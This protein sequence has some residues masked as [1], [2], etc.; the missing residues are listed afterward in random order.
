MYAGTRAPGTR[1]PATEQVPPG[2]RAY[3]WPGLTKRQIILRGTSM[4]ILSDGTAPD[5]TKRCGG[6][7][8]GAAQARTSKH[9]GTAAD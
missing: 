8:N 9:G 1:H 2:S 3:G 5:V 6:S 4:K 7:V